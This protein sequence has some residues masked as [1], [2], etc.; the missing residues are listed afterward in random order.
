[1]IKNILDCLS[2]VEKSDVL[3]IQI[4]KGK[5]KYPETMKDLKKALKTIKNK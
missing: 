2:L 1:M 3:I 4:A 5:Y